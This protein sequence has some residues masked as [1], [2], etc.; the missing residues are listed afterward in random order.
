MKDLSIALEAAWSRTSEEVSCFRTLMEDAFGGSTE[1]SIRGELAPWSWRGAARSWMLFYIICGI[2]LS[3]AC[4]PVA[5][6][7]SKESD[8]TSKSIFALV[9][10]R[11]EHI[12]TLARPRS[13]A[14]AK[15]WQAIR[16]ELLSGSRADTFRRVVAQQSQFLRR[17]ELENLPQINPRAEFSERVV[18]AG[19]IKQRVE[20]AMRRSQ[21]IAFIAIV[22]E[23]PDYIQAAKRHMLALAALDPRGA[24]GANQEDL[25]ARHI[26][27]TLAL[28]L[29]WLDSAWSAAERKVLIAAIEPRV[30]DFRVRLLEGPRSLLKDPRDSHNNAVLGAL[31]EISILL[32]GETP[33]AE[34]WMREFI[35]FYVRRLSPF[36]GEDGGYANGTSYAVWDVTEYSLRHWDT[37]RRTLGVDL[38]LTSWAR[39][40]GRYLMYFLP[41]GTPVGT[42]GDG[43][44]QS[45]PREW[46]LAAKAYAARFP[47]PEYRWYAR[48]WF[49]EDQASIDMLL[50][51][52]IEETMSLLP[53]ETQNSAFF[54][55]IGWV[56]MHSDLRDRGRTSVY[57]KSSQYGAAS[58][59]H[60]DQ[61]SFTVNSLGKP[62]LIDSGYYDSYASAHH[63][64][65]NMHTRAHNAITFDGGFGQG[66][67]KKIGWDSE[68][69]GRITQFETDG[70]I[71]ITVGDATPSYQ[72]KAAVRRA[73]VYNR[74]ANWLLVLDRVSSQ[75]RRTWEWNIHAVNRFATDESDLEVRNGDARAC[76]N[77]TSSVPSTF[78][79]S[80]KFSHEP[81][82]DS[83]NPRPSQWHGR[84]ASNTKSQT[85]DA[86]AL[87]SFGCSAS[88]KPLVQFAK[89]GIA[90][91][92]GEAAFRFSGTRLLR[93]SSR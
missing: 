52:V 12:R 73:L 35:P 45:L 61:N 30:E 63:F 44:E 78:L 71:D 14:D 32:M 10:S 23:R 77:F 4:I 69:N 36:G 49:Q 18:D 87:I 34:K 8:S 37:L 11:L 1:P 79:Q 90:V 16:A 51:P 28:G 7:Q 22:T 19:R 76:I 93:E 20:E 2:V 26:A 50:A 15:E 81:V 65:W 83:H 59:G 62:L 46:A 84:Y 43:A 27:W 91:R 33:L 29:D 40:F 53:E 86:V 41:P 85:Y 74:E 92:V 9:N 47:L 31:A 17:G 42:F 72:G 75:E 68:A 82:R 6:G 56:A 57:F 64:G 13:F 88:A 80:D 21:T 66:D 55:S 70:K 54:P 67:E 5:L 24:T 89:D 48:Q 3:I 38:T 60:Y 39:N 58:H 25:S